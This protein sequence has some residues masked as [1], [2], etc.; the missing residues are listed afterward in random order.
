VRELA[1]RLSR[2]LACGF[3]VQFAVIM[4]GLLMTETSMRA[5]GRATCDIAELELGDSLWG[6]VKYHDLCLQTIAEKE[7]GANAESGG[8]NAECGGANAESGGAN[9]ECGGLLG[10]R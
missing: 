2:K 1:I 3:R 9:A 4:A 10:V 7:A 5:R 8:A 6:P